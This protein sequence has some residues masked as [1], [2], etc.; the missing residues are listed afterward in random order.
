MLVEGE[1]EQI[2]IPTLIKKVT[3][4]SLDEL[5]I[6]LVSMGGTVFKHIS[7][8]FH[9]DRLR[10]YCAILTD[11]DEAYLTTPTAYAN[12]KD[13]DHLIAADRDGLQRKNEL[14]NYL[15]GNAYTHAFYAQN[16]F[17]TELINTTRIYSNNTDLFRSTL[18]LIYERKAFITAYE[19]HFT[20]SDESE[21]NHYVLKLANKAGKGWFA[22][23]LAENSNPCLFI[24]TYILNALSHV[25]RGHATEE[26]WK[27]MISYRLPFY[28]AG[29][30]LENYE[31]HCISKG[32]LTPNGTPATFAEFF[33][34][35][36]V[37]ILIRGSN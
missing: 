9:Q 7:D 17:E 19:K 1:A 24:P 32:V 31:K 37:A 34:H 16:T 26:I 3:G 21:R 25:L 27:K 23:L 36:P 15:T 2:L 5:G 6:S 20:S 4:I 22:L 28:K 11:R 33:E 8:L 13:V 18:P 30:T 12:Q 14:D 35:D 10:T 29:N